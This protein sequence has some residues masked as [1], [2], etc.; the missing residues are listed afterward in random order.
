MIYDFLG[1][2]IWTVALALSVATGIRVW[3]LMTDPS[4]TEVLTVWPG[5]VALSAALV[6]ILMI[7]VGYWTR[8]DGLVVHGLL[9][10]CGVNVAFGFLILLIV[11]PYES[12][13]WMSFVWAGLAAGAWLLEMPARKDS[14]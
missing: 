10:T 13:G 4:L 9:L 2:R 11:G 7:W 14:R 12:C 1:R 5:Y 3:S 8:L 6:A